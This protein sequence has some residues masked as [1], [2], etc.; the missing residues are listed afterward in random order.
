VS[1][2]KYE[3]KQA[4]GFA[5]IEYQCPAEALQAVQTFN[6]TI[7]TELIDGMSEN[8]IAV[9]GPLSAFHVIMKEEWVKLKEEMRSIKREIALLNPQHMFQPTVQQK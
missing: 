2:P 5:F 7:P 1:I 8:F 6:N 4:K 9:Q 3:S